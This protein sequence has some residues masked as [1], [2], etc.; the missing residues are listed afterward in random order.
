MTYCDLCDLPRDQCTHGR[1]EVAQRAAAQVSM[2]H[3]SP[4][5]YA[6]LPDCMHKD[7][8]DFSRWGEINEK[9]AWTRLG[10]GESIAATGGSNLSLVATKRCQTC[11]ERDSF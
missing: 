4:T 6:H 1:A 9:G 8:P 7:D 10:N 5:G 3:V 2:L 11:V